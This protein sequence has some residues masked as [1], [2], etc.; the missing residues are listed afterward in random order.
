VTEAAAWRAALRDACAAWP[1]IALDPSG[2]E[3]HAEACR[4]SGGGGAE[5]L[6][7]LYLAWAASRGDPAALRQFD[8]RVLAHVDP[9]VRAID[10]APGFADEVRQELRTRLLVAAGG[11]ARIA[12]YRGRGALLAWVRV[13]ALRA[14]LNLKRGQRPATSSAEMLGELIGRES[15][16]ETR[17]LKNLYR[18]EFAEAL[19]VVLAA[20]PER[21]RAIL[22]LHFVDGMRLAQ[23][24]ALYGVHE[25]TASRWVK[26]AVEGVAADTRSRLLERL[27]LSPSSLDS[28]TG[29]GA[30]QPGPQHPRDA[31]RRA[32]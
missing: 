13:A 20:L 2:F 30:V 29:L 1:D 14:A 25:S 28:V 7:D 3:A 32:G 22:R 18:A 4:E 8:A 17:H 6:A 15:D 24:G 10:P 5:H 23:I 27:R 26:A 31:G 11:P 16:P 19:R 21:S 9:A 12:E